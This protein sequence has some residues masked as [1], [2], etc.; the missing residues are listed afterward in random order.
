[1]LKGVKPA[2]LEVF[3]MHAKMRIKMLLCAVVYGLGQKQARLYKWYLNKESRGDGE[4][5]ED[6]G[7]MRSGARRYCCTDGGGCGEV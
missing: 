5:S 6:G 2:Q 4:I 3:F 1:M 7:G